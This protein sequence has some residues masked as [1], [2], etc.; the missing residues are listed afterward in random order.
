MFQGEGPGGGGSGR[1]GRQLGGRR[2]AGPGRDDGDSDESDAEGSRAE[3]G[4]CRG[5]TLWKWE[6]VR[7]RALREGQATEAVSLAGDEALA[8]GG[9]GLWRGARLRVVRSSS[10][11]TAPDA[12]AVC[13]DWRAPAGEQQ[14]ARAEQRQGPGEPD[15]GRHAVPRRPDR[16]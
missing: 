14:G 13:E 10:P 9:G 6:V 4:T 1:Q 3:F 8:G 15:C 2:R 12:G 16:R 7:E 5:R 11:R